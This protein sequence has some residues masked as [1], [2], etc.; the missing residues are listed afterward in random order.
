[1]NEFF[2]QISQTGIKPVQETCL[3]NSYDHITIKSHDSL[4]F[5]DNS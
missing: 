1:M 2:Y 3:S 5:G 4:L